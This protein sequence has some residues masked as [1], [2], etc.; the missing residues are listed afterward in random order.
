MNLLMRIGA[1]KLCFMFCFLL[2]VIILRCSCMYSCIL[3]GKGSMIFRCC[4]SVSL[5]LL[6]SCRL[7]EHPLIKSIPDIC[8][9]ALK[10]LQ[11]HNCN[12]KW[13]AFLFC[14]SLSPTHVYAMN[15]RLTVT[16]TKRELYPNHKC[17]VKF[18]CISEND[19]VSVKCL[20][21]LRVFWQLLLLDV[22]C[23]G[24]GFPHL[25]VR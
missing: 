2:W 3:R 12:T 21:F 19:G 22:S 11:L 25:Q 17:I 16:L 10:G 24:I 4:F 18:T 9:S 13:N 8:V 23:T 1:C 7:P 6:C 5:P 14:V 20:K 15:H